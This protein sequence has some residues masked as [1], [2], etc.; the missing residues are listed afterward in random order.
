PEGAGGGAP[1]PGR[2][3]RPRHGPDHRGAARLR[4]PGVPG[5]SPAGRRAGRGGRLMLLM[6]AVAYDPE[7]VT[8]WSRFRE[9]L[10]ARGL[11]FDFVLYANYER[12]V[13]DLIEG[14]VHLAWHSPL[15]WVRARRL[16][17]RRGPD[18]A[19]P[20]RRAPARAPPA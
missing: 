9:W 7:V 8:I 17:G 3:G 18:A 19:P 13:E 1:L 20:P 5:P 6:G 14:R 10:T 15:A 11:P 4:R 2:A 16:A 12:Q